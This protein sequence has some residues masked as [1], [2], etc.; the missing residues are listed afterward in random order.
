MEIDPQEAKGEFCEKLEINQYFLLWRIDVLNS[1]E[2][3]YLSLQP[4]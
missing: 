1:I 4:R 2:E 3:L